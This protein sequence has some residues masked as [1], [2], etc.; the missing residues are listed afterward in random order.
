[1]SLYLYDD[2]RARRFVP[3]ALTRPASELC[4][5]AVL[6]RHRW[7]RVSG[8]AAAGLLVADHL[9]DFGEFDAPPVVTQPLPAGALV[10]NS[11]CIPALAAAPDADVWT[12]QGRVAGV[13]LASSVDPAMLDHGRVALEA[14]AAP[15]A[16]RCELPGGTRWV[17]NVWDYIRDLPAQLGD[18]IPALA[19][20]L[21]L[22][23]A[24][25]AVT[26][27]GA[28]V[29]G[30]HPVYLERGAT[31]EPFA[32]LDV[33]AGPVLV[34]RGAVVQAFTRVVGP[35]AIGEATL[36]AGDRVAASSIGER[37]KVRGELSVSIIMGYTN[38]SHDGFV[39]HSYLGR[40]VN[41]GAGTVT[42]NLKNTY[43]P[44]QLWTPDAG[45]T[46]TG[47]TFL[48]AFFGDYVRTGIGTRLTTGTV[49]GAGA[50][51][52]P[53]GIA[54]KVVPP[55]AWGD[56]QP[57][58]TFEAAKF[59]EVAE[60]QMARRDVPLGPSARRFLTAVHAHAAGIPAQGRPA[61]PDPSGK[62]GR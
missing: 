18:D 42:S 55:F 1:V 29:V 34:R 23:P 43:G 40:W 50:N 35:C 2:E 26:A 25:G 12:C 58:D 41:L 45:V 21:A 61:G 31:I 30:R 20:D 32:L 14:L 19:A 54:P 16:R 4:A 62:G 33:T 3:F 7:M 27:G 48:G 8:E 46:S 57:F 44:V 59:L 38:K 9:R 39:G 6:T 10:V 52:F 5:G 22:Q 17:D 36:V 11:R 37:C 51:I 56:Q 24:A 60:R 15:S 28:T 49:I 53:T 13:R 47:L